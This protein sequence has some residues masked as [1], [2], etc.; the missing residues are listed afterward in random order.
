LYLILEGHHWANYLETIDELYLI[1]HACH[2]KVK[3]QANKKDR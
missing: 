3:R 2:A 1:P